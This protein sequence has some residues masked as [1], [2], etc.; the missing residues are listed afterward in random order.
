MASNNEYQ[1][2]GDYHLNLNPKWSYYPTYLAKRQY[3]LGLMEKFPKASAILDAGAGEGD[4][5]MELRKKG[6]VKAIG[7]DFNYESQEVQKGNVLNLDFS[8]GIFDVV[9][10]LDLLE[11]LDFASQE[12]ALLEIKRVL[13]KDGILILSVPNLAHFYSRLKFLLKG[14]LKR[15]ANIQK[16]LGDR[17]VK[18]YLVLLAKCGFLIKQRK[19]FF[20]TWPGFFN[21]ILAFPQKT[22]W[23]YNFLSLACPWPNICFLNIF[24]CQKK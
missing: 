10:C 9:L 4:F 3:V 20:P 22:L 13:K 21:L 15:T 7:L 8:S 6:F 16:H 23:L 5:V 19:G 14:E 18:E 2:R 11:H 17:P 12:K 1:Q 24:V